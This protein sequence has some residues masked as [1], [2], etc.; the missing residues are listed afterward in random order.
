VHIRTVLRILSDNKCSFI[1]L[2]FYHPL[3]HKSHALSAKSY[4]L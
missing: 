4:P 3:P 1:Y 2:L